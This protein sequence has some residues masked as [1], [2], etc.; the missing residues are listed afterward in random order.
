MNVHSSISQPVSDQGNGESFFRKFANLFKSESGSLLSRSIPPSNRDQSEN[1]ATSFDLVTPELLEDRIVVVVSRNGNRLYDLARM[2]ALS[3]IDTVTTPNFEEAERLVNSIGEENAFLIVD[4]DGIDG[5]VSVVDLLI[6]LRA[7]A[8]R[9]PIII[10]S[11]TFRR[12]DF[13][14]ARSAIADTSVRL[15]CDHVTL[16]LAVESAVQNNWSRFTL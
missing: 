15:P 3:A 11:K 10:G 1:M 5:P 2:V 7:W 8:P 4:I 16:A 14:L 12:H 9:T 13:T 6:D